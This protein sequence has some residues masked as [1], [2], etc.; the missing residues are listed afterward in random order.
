[1]DAPTD[2]QLDLKPPFL[3]PE[4]RWHAGQGDYPE[5]PP[6]RAALREATLLGGV[7]IG[8]SDG[9]LNWLGEVI[10][11]PGARRIRLVFAVYPAGPTRA[12]HL[13]AASMLAAE[14]AGSFTDVQFRVLPL[15]RVFGADCEL[16]SLPPTLIY[17]QAGE[18]AP[19]LCLGSTGDGGCDKPSVWSFN[20]V[21][22]P[23]DV[24][25]DAWR[26]WFGFIFE[27][28]APLTAETV[29]IPHLAPAPGDIEAGRAWREFVERCNSDNATRPSVETQVNPETGEVIPVATETGTPAETWDKDATKL[30]PLAHE[31]SRIYAAGKLVT[32]DESTRLKPLVVSVTAATFGEQSK[33]TVGNVLRKQQFTLEILDEATTKKVETC[34]KIGDV[35][36]LLSL[37][38]SQGVRWIPQ[39]G[40]ALL[41][42]EIVARNKRG[43][44]LLGAAV[45][46]D[47]EGFVKKREKAIRE[48][49]SAMYRD[50]GHGDQ[51]P[52]DRVQLV[53]KDVS[54]RLEKALASSVAPTPIF[55]PIAAPN[56]TNAAGD[57]AW[58]QPLSLALHAARGF[59]QSITDP[60]FQRQFKLLAFKQD[61][62]EAAM[63]VFG[64]YLRKKREFSS[65]DD[66]LAVLT[67]IESSEDSLL[68]KCRKVVALIRGKQDQGVVR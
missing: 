7:V 30:D 37:Q 52:E 29:Q 54:S 45:G 18:N 8:L 14:A 21:F 20:A 1:M 25:R 24:L 59:R 36:R 32:V 22:Q 6:F 66:E 47:V 2:S 44:E 13:L 53:L 34:R 51:M 43:A 49:L 31:F 3:W 28:A 26:R 33:K 12:E 16:P 46:G 23:D 39:A 10:H 67:E 65:A 61:E 68:E 42:R 56:L 50:L 4:A 62:F 60:Y 15:E 40:I 5:Q 19:L 57:A 58:T 17:V 41:E 38:L 9:T 11:R 48:N 27:K 63:D 64:D 35:V 55:N